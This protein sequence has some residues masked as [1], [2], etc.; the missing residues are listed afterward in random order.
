MLENL[1]YLGKKASTTTMNYDVRQ[2]KWEFKDYEHFY[3]CYKYAQ[4]TL[5]TFFFKMFLFVPLF[6]ENIRKALIFWRFQEVLKWRICLQCLKLLRGKKIRKIASEKS[7]MNYQIF[8]FC[9]T[10]PMV[11]KA[12]NWKIF[13]RCCITQWT[14]WTFKNLHTYCPVSFTL[15]LVITMNS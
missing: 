12:W 3:G 10:C 14:F 11:I 9:I 2:R 4:N 7:W 8:T 5:L 1:P 6:P 13:F 15:Y